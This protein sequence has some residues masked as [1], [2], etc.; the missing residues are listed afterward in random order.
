MIPNQVPK[1]TLYICG[2][3]QTVFSPYGEK[4]LVKCPKCGSKN[5][6]ESIKNKTEVVQK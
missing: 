2:K 4:V 3:C 6:V 1:S 5:I